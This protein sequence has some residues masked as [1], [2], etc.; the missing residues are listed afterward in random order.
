MLPR[1][2]F[3]HTRVCLTN[4]TGQIEKRDYPLTFIT[5][6]Q[7]GETR[8][9]NELKL[10]LQHVPCNHQPLDFA[11]TFADGHQAGIAV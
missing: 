8:F 7:M 5:L 2:G 10:H 1:D 6:L 9:C 4:L 3:D 11:G